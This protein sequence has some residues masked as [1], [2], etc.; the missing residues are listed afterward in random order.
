MLKDLKLARS[1]TAASG[2]D[3]ALGER[4]ATIYA[5]L[6]DEGKGGADFSAVIKAI[7]SRSGVNLRSAFVPK[8]AARS[9][10]YACRLSRTSIE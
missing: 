10:M 2:V 6:N 7:R 3:T 4:A 8:F 5:R 9:H 1:A